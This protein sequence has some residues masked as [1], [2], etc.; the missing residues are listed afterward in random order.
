MALE[1]LKMAATESPGTLVGW[2][3]LSGGA[4]WAAIKALP[5]FNSTMDAAAKNALMQSSMLSVLQDNLDKAHALIEEWRKEREALVRT[6]AAA[7]AQITILT[8]R[9]AMLNAMLEKFK[10]GAP[11]Q[12]NTGEQHAE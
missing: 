3:L 12:P 11:A 9:C 10:A 2:G 4:I 1:E 7:E 8:E 6:L 5:L